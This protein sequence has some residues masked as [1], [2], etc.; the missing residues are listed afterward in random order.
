MPDATP[1]VGNIFK[2]L[3]TDGSGDLDL[4]EVKRGLHTL[5]LSAD[6]AEAAAVLAKYDSD[7]NGRLSLPE[8]RLLVKELR[9]FQ[10]SQGTPAPPIAAAAG[11]GPSV[12]AVFRSHDKD[13]SGELD[14]LELRAALNDLGLSAD[15]AGA[16][17]VLKRYDSNGDGRLSLQE[18]RPLVKELREFQSGA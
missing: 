16:A 3:D 9:A 5:G 14:V 8:F 18:F 2:S 12:G 1:S 4:A 15:T 13:N 7:H 11:A 10:Q 6:T 17:D